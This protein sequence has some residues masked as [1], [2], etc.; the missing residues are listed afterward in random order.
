MEY[1]SLI[2]DVGF[3]I[4]AFCIAVYALKYAYDKSFSQIAEL[5]E[6]VNSNTQILIKLVERMETHDN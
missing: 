5:T 2:S 4:F 6:A 1:V 3:P